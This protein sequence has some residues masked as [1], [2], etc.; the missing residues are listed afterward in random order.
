MAVQET[1]PTIGEGLATARGRSTTNLLP[2]PG[3]LNTSILP[4]CP[5]TICF[6]TD[7]PQPMPPTQPTFSPHEWLKQALAIG[8]RHANAAI[9]DRYGRGRSRLGHSNRDIY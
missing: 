4:R 5:S 2:A 3:A 9:D 6:V 1:K 7:N 8:R